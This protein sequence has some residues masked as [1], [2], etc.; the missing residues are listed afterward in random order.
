MFASCVAAP[1]GR[2]STGWASQW[3]EVLPAM[4]RHGTRRRGRSDR[5]RERDR[6]R[7][8]ERERRAQQEIDRQTE[9]DDADRWLTSSRS[10]WRVMEQ[11]P[12]SDPARLEKT[13]TKSA[14]LRIEHRNTNISEKEPP[15]VFGTPLMETGRQSDM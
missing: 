6:E 2:Y 7:E 5:V 14:T 11:S 15:P 8:K 10:S 1:D 3:P 9:R 4:S 12:S 13:I